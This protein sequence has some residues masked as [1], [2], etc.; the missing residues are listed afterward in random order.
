MVEHIVMWKLLEEAEGYSADENFERAR[1]ALLALPEK[2]AVIRSFDL[3]R[4]M[5]PD[6]KNADM[7]LLSSFDSLEDLSYYAGHPEHL[8]VGALIGKIT[9]GRAA[10]DFVV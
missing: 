3:K 2:I 1:K 4:N 9:T 5:N 8:L 10:I 7:V 6:A